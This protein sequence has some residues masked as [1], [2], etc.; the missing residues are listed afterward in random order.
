MAAITGE[1]A[2]GGQCAAG[3][4]AGNQPGRLG[5]ALVAHL[6]EDRFGDVVVRP[7]VGGALGE[8]ELVH[9]MP[10]ALARQPFG[11]GVNLR[12]V[13]DQV[14]L[15]AIEGDLRD[16]LLGGAGRHHGNERQSEQAG[17]IG[18]GNRRRTAGRLDHRRSR[19]QPAVAQR[20]EEQRAR[21][22]VLEAAGGV[23]GLVLEVQ[24]DAR[25]AGQIEGDQ[26]RVGAALEVRLDDADCLASPG[27][28]VVQHGD[29]SQGMDSIS[30]AHR[31]AA[32]LA[33]SATG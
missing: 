19:F 9:E 25:H 18:F 17:E 2:E 15:A 3:A 1:A 12:R 29:T 14:A 26:V 20:I 10:A 24:V 23:A 27:A 7:P 22:A 5:E 4:G 13:V 28:F 11:L 8:G 6:L 31:P 21:Q 32:W 16:L 33:R 30:P